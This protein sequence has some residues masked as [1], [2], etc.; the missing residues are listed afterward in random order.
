MVQP[1]EWINP[2][3]EEFIPEAMSCVQAFAD[4]RDQP[5]REGID[6]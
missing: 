4:R 3:G 1:K 6:A 2:Q 5:A